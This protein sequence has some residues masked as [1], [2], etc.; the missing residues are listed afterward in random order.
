MLCAFLDESGTHKGAPVM[1]V[2]GVLFHE[3]GVNRLR[4]AW[5]R[6]LANAGLSHFH[7]TEY[8]HFGSQFREM[9]EGNAD[10]LYKRLIAIINQSC[11][12]SRTVCVRPFGIFDV[13]RQKRRYTQ[14]TICAF[15]CIELL[16]RMAKTFGHKTLSLFIENGHNNIGELK[17][18]LKA[19]RAQGWCGVTEY[20]IA[21]KQGPCHIQTA[22][23]CAYE[24]LRRMNDMTPVPAKREPRPT[25][26]EINE[27]RNHKFTIIT[28]E[29][30]VSI[31]RHLP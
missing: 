12:G 24:L 6:E 5:Q 10:A 29:V 26:Q 21:G 27:D 3:K 23:I 20:Q 7:M 14:Y 2:T 16:Y 17:L 8:F 18:A 28:E 15:A 31:L 9:G 4:T 11:L 22:D 19:K 13:F 30:L 1:C 25:F